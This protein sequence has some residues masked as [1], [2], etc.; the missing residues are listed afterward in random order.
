MLKI[1]IKIK[2]LNNVLKNYIFL[3]YSKYIK[4]NYIKIQI[5]LSSIIQFLFLIVL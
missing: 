4:I 2:F 5:K 3:N 1:L